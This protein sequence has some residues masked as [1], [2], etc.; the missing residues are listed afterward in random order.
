MGPRQQLKRLITWC[1]KNKVKINTE[2]THVIFNESRPND[3]IRYGETVIKTTQKIKYLGAEIISNRAENRSTFLI[4]TDSVASHIKQ[5][6][7]A[8][9]ALRKYKIPEKQFKQECQ[10]FI[11]GKLNYYTPWLAAEFAIKQTI[12]PLELAYNEYMR[13]YTGCMV[14]TPIPVLHAISRF[15]L[16]Q[17]KI[18]ADTAIAILKAKAQGTILAEDYDQ[19]NG[20]APEWTPF[21]SVQK[22]LKSRIAEG[23]NIAIHPQQIIKPNILEKLSQ[24]NFHLGT[25][26]SALELH[27]QGKLIPQVQDITIWTDGSLNRDVIVPEI[28]LECGAAALVQVSNQESESGEQPSPIVIKLMIPNAVS[29]YETEIIAIQAGLEA[30]LSVK[31]TERKI[32]LFTDSLSC[33]QQLACL[34]Y[35]YIYTNA[36]VADVAEKLGDVDLHFIPSHTDQIPESDIIDELAKAA[37]LEGEEIDH[38]PPISTYKL[39]LRKILQNRLY[40]YLAKNVKRSSNIKNL[41]RAPLI[42]GSLQIRNCNGIIT[43]KINNDHALL[44]RVRSGHTCTRSHLKHVNIESDDTCRHCGKE[45]ETIEHQLI[46]CSA[47][48]RN[49]QHTDTNMKNGIYQISIKHFTTPIADSYGNFSQKQKNTGATYNK[50]CMK[51]VYRQGCFGW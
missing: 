13:T 32:H 2:K 48:R 38:D 44:N 39:S 4:G 37:A 43:I 8:I 9:K 5:R 30:T 47:M 6:C 50:Y 40:K 15:P 16:F 28:G 27:K 26:L 14:T 22:I 35:K 23:I 41:D 18:L 45:P 25:K 46:K 7:L 34:P 1:T 20:S 12:R 29:S 42:I 49:W 21:S 11:G 33:L 31:P 17:D 10:A 19:W 24:C 3:Q 51:P 36:V